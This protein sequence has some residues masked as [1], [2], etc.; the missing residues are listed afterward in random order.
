[1]GLSVP[2]FFDN[3]VRFCPHTFM[4]SMLISLRTSHMRTH[5]HAYTTPDFS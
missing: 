3:Q 4:S 1:M 2:T 5:I